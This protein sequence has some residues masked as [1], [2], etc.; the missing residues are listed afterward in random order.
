MKIIFTLTTFLICLKYYA[1]PMDSDIVAML[2]S[3]HESDLYVVVKGSGYSVREFEGEFANARN[4]EWH[5]TTIMSISG[6]DPRLFVSLEPMLHPVH[7]SRDRNAVYRRVWFDGDQWIYDEER[8]NPN[9]SGRHNISTVIT[10]EAP[11]FLGN[12]NEDGD[13]FGLTFVPWRYGVFMDYSLLRVFDSKNPFPFELGYQNDDSGGIV[14]KLM[15][16]CNLSEIRV[17]SNTDQLP[18]ITTI[19]QYYNM[20]RGRETYPFR[21]LTFTD[22]IDDTGPLGLSIPRAFE[23]VFYNSDGTI[24]QK[25]FG[26]L[27]SFRIVDKAY[28]DDVFAQMNETSGQVI[29]DRTS[30]LMILPSGEV[31]ELD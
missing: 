29:I 14:L 22:F 24:R 5:F 30:G 17:D 6:N 2:T 12:V 1:A 4:G 8:I 31:R 15:N 28:V 27:E 25:R 18:K 7:N 20:C 16:D 10:K 26:Q 19:K 11:S 23:F 21:V 9:T 3:I 13:F